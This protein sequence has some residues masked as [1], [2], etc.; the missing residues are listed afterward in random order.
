[1]VTIAHFHG[2]HLSDLLAIAP[3][4]LG[5]WLLTLSR[6]FVRRLGRA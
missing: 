1:M 3:A 2:I 6:P 4:L 5:A